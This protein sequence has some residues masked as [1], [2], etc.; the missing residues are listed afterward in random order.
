MHNSRAVASPLLSSPPPRLSRLASRTHVRED[1]PLARMSPS[2]SCAK[3][4]RASSRARATTTSSRASAG[5]SRVYHENKN[6]TYYTIYVH[7]EPMVRV[8]Q[9]GGLHTT[10]RVRDDTSRHIA[11]GR[12]ARVV[13]RWR[14]PPPPRPQC[15][16]GTIGNARHA[17]GVGRDG[18]DGRVVV[19]L[20][21]DARARE[22]VARNVRSRAIAIERDARGDGETRGQG[23]SSRSTRTHGDE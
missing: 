22:R 21:V 2:R 8:S 14:V 19:S 1:T 17:R 9:H 20:V 12:S 23:D 7:Y 4:T 15:A 18:D 11:R 10:H 16:T 3:V 5:T 13:T 6:N